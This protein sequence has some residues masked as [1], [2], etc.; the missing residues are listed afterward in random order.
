MNNSS[1]CA[2]ISIPS[3]LCG[4]DG[5]SR[6]SAAASQDPGVRW[7]TGVTELQRPEITVTE[8]PATRFLSL[9]EGCLHISRVKLKIILHLL[10]SLLG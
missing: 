5:Q 9:L 7:V 3:V 1:V 8:N 10:V 2:L 4:V 6:R